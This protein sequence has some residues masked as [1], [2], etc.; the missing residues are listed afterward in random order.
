[1]LGALFSRG[2]IPRPLV[3]S[4]GP[5][6]HQRLTVYAKRGGSGVTRL[7]GGNGEN[8]IV[9]NTRRQ[10]DVAGDVPYFL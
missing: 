9:I 5:I 1:M 7:F 10:I 8:L 4:P 6:T 3:H 2:E